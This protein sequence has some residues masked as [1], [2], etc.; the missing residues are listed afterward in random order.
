MD[1]KIM[2]NLKSESRW[3]R[4][5]F[6]LLFVVAGYFAAII[7][8]MTGIVQAIHGFVTGEP[9]ARLLSLSDSINQYL[10]QILQYITYN[11]ESKP[12]PF[13]DWPESAQGRTPEAGHQEDKQ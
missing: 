10:F 5:V 12:Y 11:S 9:N 7:A 3:L 2:E 4:L 6:M 13:S 8:L 1:D